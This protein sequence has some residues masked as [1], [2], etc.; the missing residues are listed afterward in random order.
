MTTDDERDLP[1]GEDFHDETVALA[2]AEAAGRLR[3]WRPL[4]FDQFV[5]AVHE[6][7]LPAARILEL[8]SGPGLLAEHVLDRCP[9]VACYTLLDFSAAMLAQSRRRL[10]RHGA[11][12][13]FV[14]ADFKSESWPTEVAR[15]VDLVLS[16][17]AV[18]E[19]RHK[20]H[21][22]RLYAQ[23]RSLLSP[24]AALV[25]CDHLPDG[26]RTPRHRVLYMTIAEH[27][28]VLT[29]AGYRDAEVLWSGHAMALYRA[30]V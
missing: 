18:H 5:S 13:H 26:A 20:R 3:P 25:V 7:R 28:A 6:A 29:N 15:P 27:L 14:H 17:Q 2:W 21:A 16:M 23:V 9:S 22:P 12:T 4:I 24:A 8:G 11:R 30:R 10:D 1:Y 19:L